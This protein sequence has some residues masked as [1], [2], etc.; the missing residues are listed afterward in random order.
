M[1]NR[2]HVMPRVITGL[3]E[4]A[5][6]NGINKVWG[7]DSLTDLSRIPVNIQESD[8]S[9]DLHVIAPGLKKEDFK[10]NI[11]RNILTISFDHQESE[12]ETTSK[13]L[14]REYKVKSFKRS[15]TLNDKIQSGGISARYNDGILH[16][17]L[18]KK[19]Q[20]EATSQDINVL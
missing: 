7:D 14:R 9:Y 18:P 19:E 5:F 17:T 4:D 10:V 3:L 8:A 16:V 12:A 1:Y 20:Q 13:W 15:F 2:N 6:A 11:D